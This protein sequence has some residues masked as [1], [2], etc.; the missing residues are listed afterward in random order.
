VSILG[1]ASDLIIASRCV[2]CHELSLLTKRT[3]AASSPLLKL[4]DDLIKEFNGFAELLLVFLRS[5]GVAYP[6]LAG[7]NIG[8]D[9]LKFRAP[10]LS[11]FAEAQS[12]SPMP[13]RS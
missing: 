12:K 2:V 9:A 4:F 8:K 3:N 5:R 7:F 11:I 6:E 13:R 1:S 10:A